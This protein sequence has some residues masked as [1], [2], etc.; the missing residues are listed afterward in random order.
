MKMASLFAGVGGFDLA[1]ERVGIHVAWQS[2][3]DANASSVLARHWPDVPNYGDITAIDG[4]AVEPVDV[5]TGGFPCQDLSVAGRRAGL[6]GERSGLY[7]EIVRLVREMRDATDGRFPTFVVLENVPGLLSSHGGRDFAVVLRELRQLGAMDIGWRV[8]DAQHFGVPQRRRRVFVVADFGGCRAG[9]IL[10]EPEGGGGDSAA[11]RT[12]GEEIAGSLGVGSGAGGWGHDLDANG[13]FIPTYAI[14]GNAIGRKPEN[15][16]Q[17][18]EILDDG[19]CFNLTTV[20]R[21]AVAAP[22]TAGSNPHSNAAGRRRENDENLVAF[23]NRGNTS[24]G[25]QSRRANAGGDLAPMVAAE[26][27]RSDSHGALPMVAHSLTAEGH[28]ASEDGTGRG[29]PLAVL[30]FDTTQV[31]SDKNYSNPKPGDPCHPIAAGMHAPSVATAM[32]VRR[33]TPRECERLQGFPDDHTRYGADGAEMSDS[34]RYRM[35]GNAV[36]VPVVTWIL[37]RLRDAA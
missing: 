1:A 8:L 22:L 21:H 5:I 26:R 29:T 34:A 15:G 33:L 10:F 11:C 19:T 37:Q 35:C 23:T 4:A 9:E 17:R 3:I 2:E 32:A 25:A 30:P 24:V 6:A 16:P 20:D 27:L 13:A 12:P 36:A 28:D 7:F 18:G 31:T 14:A